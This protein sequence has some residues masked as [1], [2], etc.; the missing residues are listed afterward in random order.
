M[1]A[2]VQL[3][4]GATMRTPHGLLDGPP[5]Q[6]HRVALLALLA[7]A[8]PG[9]VARDRAMALLWPDRDATRARALLNLAV[10][11]LRGALGRDAIR[12]AGD[13]LA[14]GEADID[15][16]AFTRALTAG[17]QERAL[18]SYAGPFLDGFHLC[19]SADFSRWQ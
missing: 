1:S 18:A 2:V 16:V 9:A 6:R 13:H 19:A 17:D 15:V 11:V 14:L 4:G 8:Y 7:S 5:V 3:L 12:S 10:H